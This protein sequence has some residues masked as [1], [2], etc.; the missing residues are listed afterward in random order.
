MRPNLVI[1]ECS[2][3][4]DLTENN[5][6]D[7]AVY[8]T[9]LESTKAIPWKIDWTTSQFEYIGPQIEDLLGCVDAS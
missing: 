8:K 7:N 5:T 1:M 6:T 2:T 9:L 4:T 3:M